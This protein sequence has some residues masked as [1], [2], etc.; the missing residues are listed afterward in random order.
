MRAVAIAAVMLSHGFLAT[1]A[2]TRP[3][4]A[5][6]YLTGHLGGLG[7]AVF[8]AIS[9]YL[10]TTLLLQEHNLRGFYLRRAFRI[11]PAA[12]LYLFVV[13]IAEPL[14]RGELASAAFFYSNYWADRSWYTAHFWSLSMEEH[15]YLLWPFLL[16]YLGVRRALIAASVLVAITALWR[17]WSLA[18]THL[19]YPA[20]QRT[21]M[22]LDAFLFAGILAIL[23]SGPSRACLLHVLTATWFRVL[24]ALTLLAAW[25]WALAGSAPA[26]GTLIESALLP[27]ILLSL[28]HWPRSAVFRVLES[29][30]LRWM[31]RISYGL[32]LWQQLFLAPHAG[33]FF[34]RVALTFAAAA[35]SYY[36]I[37]QPLLRYA[38]E[39]GRNWNRQV[40]W[41]NEFFAENAERHPRLRQEV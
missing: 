22:R 16:V 11:L 37:E 26:T 39:P 9:G 7:V 30:P 29:A 18:H 12:Y 41:N 25:T 10:I 28:V 17:P 33:A 15:F 2:T 35:A 27:A 34:T 13:S 4:R 1:N 3:S 40:L 20:L 31:G 19:L 38:R 21:D 36:L 23:M 6:G 5:L 24:S 8:F 14:R 32:Y